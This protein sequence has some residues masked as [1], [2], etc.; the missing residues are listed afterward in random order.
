MGASQLTCHALYPGQ[1]RTPSTFSHMDQKWWKDLHS[2]KISSPYW[3]RRRVNGCGTA[4]S[5]KDMGIVDALTLGTAIWVSDGS[6]NRATAPLV[7][8]DGWILCCTSSK[9]R[10]YGSFFERSSWAGSYHG[11]LLGLLVIHTL[12]A[13]LESFFKISIATG[14]FAATTSGRLLNWRNTDVESP[15][16]HWKPTLNAHSGI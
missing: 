8:G 13:A 11:E 16:V 10:L 1:V 12:T 14:K 7:S 6:F 3:K 4:F 2:L 5:M 9:K 15:P